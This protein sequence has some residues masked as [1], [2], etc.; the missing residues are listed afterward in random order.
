MW[1]KRKRKGRMKRM[2]CENNVEEDREI[3]K[4]KRL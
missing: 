4:E 2:S 3:Y 1:I